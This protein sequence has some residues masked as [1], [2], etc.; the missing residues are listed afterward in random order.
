MRMY[1]ILI[2]AMV[3]AAIV[4][5]FKL[6]GP[7]KQAS[8]SLQPVSESVLSLANLP[9]GGY[10]NLEPVNAAELDR[11]GLGGPAPLVG[12]PDVPFEKNGI[13]WSEPFS[14][15]AGDTVQ[16]TVKNASPVSW[17]GVDWINYDIRGILATTEVDEDGRAFDP[18]YPANSSLEKKPDGCTLTINYKIAHDTDCVVVVKNTNPLNSQKLSLN[19]ALKPSL[20]IRRILKDIP[21]INH[22]V[23]SDNNEMED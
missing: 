2:I 18:Q 21:L 6:Q 20:S 11:L 16:I 7:G 15:V 10:L 19:V 5:A 14:L 8:A 17:F 9:A 23:S 22:L 4:F 13:Y 1:N 3:T 12:P